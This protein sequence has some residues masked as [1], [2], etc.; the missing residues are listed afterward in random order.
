MSD[1]AQKSGPLAGLRI[2]DLTAVV[3]GP[4][5]TQILGDY[6]AEI[7]K[8]ESPA[9]D[10]MRLNGVSLH[11]GMSSIFLTLNRNK[12][13]LALDLQ[14]PAGADVLRRLIPTADV[15]VHNMRVEAIARLGFGYDAV[16]AL[17]PD[18]VYCAATGFDQDGPDAAKPAFDDI[19]QAGCGLAAVASIGREAPDYV[20]SLIA[21]KT[22]GM[23]VVNAVLA[24]LLH[25]ARSG[26]GQYV[27]VPML[28]T[29]VAFVLTEHLGGLAFE[30]APAPPGYAR[31]LEGGRKPAPTKDGY[32][33]LLPYSAPHWRAFFAAAGK[34]EIGEE[35]A[36]DDRAKRNANNAKLYAAMRATT[37]ER[38]TAEWMA[39]CAACDIPATPIYALDQLLEHPQLQAVGLFQMTQHPSEGAVRQVR[40][41]TKFADSP[42]AIR[43]PA[44]AHGEHSD[45]ILREAG[46][47]DAE[48]AALHTDNI[49]IQK[50]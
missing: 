31:L 44:P 1:P 24:A 11:R 2:L 34:P 19:I 16:A 28:E 45:E 43:S 40:P 39:I 29:M 27:E 22:A 41:A 21:D 12:R 4:Y 23:A 35:L 33:A 38:T 48:I 14:T 42:A 37:P 50:E 8:I 46:Y 5:A 49:V 32:I 13:S 47:S 26:R 7:V 20:P 3:L 30:P 6:G 17:K 36:D 18:I 15:L 10:L 25:R 9:G